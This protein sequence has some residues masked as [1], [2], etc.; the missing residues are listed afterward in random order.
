MMAD[1]SD[2]QEEAAVKAAVTG[3]PPADPA[4]LPYAREF[5]YHQ[6]DQ[7]ARWNLVAMV[8]TGGVVLYCAVETFTESHWYVIG[9]VVVLWAQLIFGG[10]APGT[11]AATSL[12]SRAWMSS[13]S[14]RVPDRRPRIWLAAAQQ[15]W[16]RRCAARP[17][18]F[19]GAPTACVATRHRLRAC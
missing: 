13:E 6:M 16:L 5:I 10:S 9:L 7:D 18:A 15:I 2:T 14:T 12:S 8:L 19:R 4:L 1:L 11:S 3:V 17:N